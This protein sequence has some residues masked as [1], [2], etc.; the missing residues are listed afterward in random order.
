M[1][2]P[3]DLHPVGEETTHVHIEAGSQVYLD[4]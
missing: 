3:E 4:R 1:V 2:Q